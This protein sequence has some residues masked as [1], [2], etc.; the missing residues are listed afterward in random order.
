MGKPYALELG[1]LPKTYEWARKSDVDA[2]VTI[3]RSLASFP[4][5]VI[6]SGG[7]LTAANFVSSLHQT[8]TG[9]ISKATTPLDAISIATKQRETSALLLSAGGRNRDILAAFQKL[10]DFEPRR[11]A[12]IC[13]QPD[14]PLIRLAS[15]YKYVDAVEFTLPSGKDGF[16][17]T[18][19]L[20]AFSVLLCRAYS[21]AF[22][23]IDNVPRRISTLAHPGKTPTQF[24][25]Q[26]YRQTAP[27][28]ELDT[29]V[30]LYGPTIQS[31]AIDMESKF[32]E[33]ALGKVQISDFRN[34]AHGRHHWLAKRASESGVLAFVT[35]SDRELARRTL[36]LIPSRIPTVRLNIPHSEPLS[37]IAAL[38]H[39]FYLVAFAGK[40]EGIDPGRP[41]VPLFGRNIYNLGFSY[42]QSSSSRSSWASEAMAI[43]RKI[44]SI[45]SS[46]PQKTQ[47]RTWRNA[48]RTFVNAL[49]RARLRAVVMDYD[50]TLCDTP[51]RFKPLSTEV[52][53]ELVRL[54]KHGM[55]IGIATGRGKSA[56]KEL[57]RA[58]PPAL[59]GRVVVG[60]YN[61]A[62]IGSLG[63]KLHPTPEQRPA[64][65]MRTIAAAFKADLRLAHFAHCEFRSNQ[66]SVAPKG[67]TSI[68]QVWEVCHEIVSN[69]N[70]PGINV[71]RTSHSVD[72]LAPGVSKVKVIRHI[73][74]TFPDCA[75]KE[76]LCIGDQGG[77]SC[78]D[79]DLLRQ[80]L[81]LSVNQ[82]SYDPMTCWN[83]APS[84]HSGLQ[85]TLDYLSA[86]RPYKGHFK[87]FIERIGKHES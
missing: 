8:Y 57:G 67:V 25:S 80:P 17:S 68:E 45:A 33:A 10:V 71:L 76:T 81:S 84:G 7:S 6:G 83:L 48:Y 4:L 73:E 52:T 79:Y 36:R 74:N 13:L 54:L 34:F 29:T 37:N 53:R 30:V 49:A 21:M 3:I 9:S 22:T 43:Q 77:W 2:L 66:I 86:I 12:V 55:I 85:A 1:F 70:V 47:L 26:L 56:R 32:T 63:D 69:V 28:W 82:V 61:G 24:A 14:T 5:F 42:K 44:G 87:F 23:K 39:V 78:N 59:Q 62:D 20:L 50:G 27:L 65:M 58:I 51:D 46:T 15:K 35:A 72:V 38:V 16:L 19:S 41:G 60:Y 40:A 11:L 31:A 18:N 75:G 64:G